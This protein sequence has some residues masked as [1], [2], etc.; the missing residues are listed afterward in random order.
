MTQ[1]SA[2]ALGRKLRMG[3]VGGGKD[4]FIGAVHRMAAQLDGMIELTAGAFSSNPEKSRSSGKKLY[5]SEDRIY[6]TYQQMFESERELPEGDRI[7]FVSIVTPNDT[8][9]PIAKMALE[10]GF[11]VMC[12][13]P[14]TFNVE[15]AVR[16][17]SIVEKSN[18]LFGLTHNYTGYPMVKHARHLVHSGALGLIRKVVVEYPQGW[19]ATRLEVEGQK[20]AL[21]RTNPARA[22]GSCCIGDIGSHAENLAEYITGLKMAQVCADLTTFVE[23][24][25]LEDDG[26]VLVR[27]HGGARG[28]IHAS[29]ISVDD[30]NALNIRVYGEKGGLEWHQQEP[31]TLILKHIDRPRQHIRAGV[32]Y[33]HLSM[34]ALHNTRLPSGHPEGFL[35]AFAN[36]YRNFAT[37]LLLVKVGETPG[38]QHLDFPNV[39]DGLRGMHFI[40]AV[41]KSAQSDKKWV[42]I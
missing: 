30:E 22:G 20:Q 12:E 40:E 21:W 27:F 33:S 17:K 25:Q 4:A 37:S 36:L 6:P 19:L 16:L 34:P 31:N 18:L 13:K 8:H 3:M 32:N 9:F 14:M 38:P 1:N 42:E 23:G 2:T 7:D 26:N 39:D 10:N 29:Q 5:L 11:H 24:R 15:E 35:E 28:I 41:L